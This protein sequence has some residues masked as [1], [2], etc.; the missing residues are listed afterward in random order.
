MEQTRV[1]RLLKLLS[2]I[3]SGPGWDAPRLAQEFGVDVRTIYRDIAGLAEVGL[4]CEYDR[5]RRGYKA[6]D[7]VFLP[8]VQLSVEEALSLAVLCEHVAQTGAIPY[9]QAACRAIQKLRCVLPESTRDEV[10]KMLESVWVR[11]AASA[12]PTEARDVYD[13]VTAAVRD[14][15]VLEC[16]YDSLGGVRQFDFHPYAMFFCVRAWYVV[17]HHGMHNEIRTLKLNRFAQVRHAGRTFDRP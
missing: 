1:H 3:H 16:Q 14:R 9:L 4:P 5:A 10:G 2:L 6:V 15:Q 8:P 7:G 11:T 12:D 13:L 17:G